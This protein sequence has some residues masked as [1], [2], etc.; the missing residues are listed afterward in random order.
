MP[1]RPDIFSQQMLEDTL[2]DVGCPESCIAP[3]VSNFR[4]FVPLLF[5]S[6]GTEKILNLVCQAQ[7]DLGLGEQHAAWRSSI[8][9]LVAWAEQEIASYKLRRNVAVPKTRTEETNQPKLL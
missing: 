7:A 3:T 5:A 9:Y 2:R 6:L 1:R 4:L 8:K